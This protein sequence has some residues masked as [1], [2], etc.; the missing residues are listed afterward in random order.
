MSVKLPKIQFRA[1]VIKSIGNEQQRSSY[2]LKVSFESSYMH[3]SL[4]FER[5]DESLSSSSWLEEVVATVLASA[6]AHF[7]PSKRELYPSK[8][9]SN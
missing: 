9:A 5:K 4:L 8:S 3:Y 2:A 7:S 6:A 1:N